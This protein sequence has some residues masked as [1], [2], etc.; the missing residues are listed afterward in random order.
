MIELPRVTGVKDIKVSGI[1]KVVGDNLLH[2]ARLCHA[3]LVSTY[4]VRIVL[5]PE[6]SSG[7]HVFL[8]SC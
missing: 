6:P 7:R 1:L 2:R 4:H 8:L 5:G 3:E